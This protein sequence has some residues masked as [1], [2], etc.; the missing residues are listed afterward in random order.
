MKPRVKRAKEAI[1]M[2]MDRNRAG[3]TEAKSRG[4]WM[5]LNNT[6][7]AEERERVG[8]LGGR[9]N[10]RPSKKSDSPMAPANQ[11]QNAF[12]GQ[13]MHYIPIVPRNTVRGKYS[14]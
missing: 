14:T 3:S 12:D 7:P 9:V 13:Q 6:R 2:E 10:S 11:C 8:A 4:T 1:R 5:E